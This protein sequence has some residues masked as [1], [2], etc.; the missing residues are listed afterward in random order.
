MMGNLGGYRELR[1]RRGMRHHARSMLKMGCG[2]LPIISCGRGEGRRE[3]SC[4]TEAA[5][6][7]G[8]LFRLWQSSGRSVGGAN[9]ASNL[10]F[11]RL[12]TLPSHIR[13]H[14]LSSTPPLSRKNSCCHSPGW[15][16]PSA[17]ASRGLTAMR[18][19]ADIVANL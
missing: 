10:S 13:Y 11:H 4:V 8:A 2:M 3:N 5:L 16:R 7:S 12:S 14:S 1:E 18:C 6:A 19:I 17:K 9:E 15:V